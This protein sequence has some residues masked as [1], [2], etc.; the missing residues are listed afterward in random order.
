MATLTRL[1]ILYCLI[2]KVHLDLIVNVCDHSF[3][4]LVT[5][6]DLAFDLPILCFNCSTDCAF[7][8]VIVFED[9]VYSCLK[10]SAAFVL[11]LVKVRYS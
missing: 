7:R 2:P 10:S 8:D 11:N 5:D 6:L 1:P 9:E 4:N 3:S